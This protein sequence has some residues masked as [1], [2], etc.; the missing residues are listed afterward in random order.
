L[1]PATRLRMIPGF[2]TRSFRVPH[3]PI[4]ERWI[5]AV[6]LALEEAFGMIRTDGFDLNNAVEDDITLELERAFENWLLPADTNDL[7][8]SFIRSVT[9][10]SATPNFDESS[11]G[12]KPDLVFRLNRRELCQTHDLSKDSLFAECKPVGRAHPLSQH[13]CAVGKSTSG[14]E[15]F[16]AG[17]YAATMEQGLMIGYARDGFQINSH[18]AQAL[19]TP[20]AIAGLGDPSE[21]SKVLDPQN[22]QNQ[23]LWLSIHQRTFTWDDGTPASPIDLYHSWHDC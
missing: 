9:R 18:L 6:H 21:L 19:K 5:A 7:D 1:F 4:S 15:R 20:K 11:I 3:P 10:E 22:S 16:V 13:Y 14:I 2:F 8:L 12:R 23:G 17:A